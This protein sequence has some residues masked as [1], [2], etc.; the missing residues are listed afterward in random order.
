MVNF[1]VISHI[2]T[3]FI[4]KW[5]HF[6]VEQ[7]FAYS[8]PAVWNSLPATLHNSSV[9]LSTFKQQRLKT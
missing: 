2:G 5:N 8:E 3:L 4:Y 9:S 7:S 6:V 1:I